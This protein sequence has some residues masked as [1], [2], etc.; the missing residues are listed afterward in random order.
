MTAQQDLEVALPNSL[1]AFNLGKKVKVIYTVTRN[2]VPQNSDELDLTVLLITDGDAN[3]PTPAIDGAIGD[4]LEVMQLAEGAQLRI[5]KWL[6]QAP[7]QCI[8]LRYDGT[9]KNGDAVE[10]TFWAG[11]AHQQVEGL[12]T[13][14][15]V[16]WLR[17]LKDKLP[18]TITFK[19]NFDKIPN[20]ATAVDF[21]VRAY[22]AHTVEYIKPSITKLEDKYEKE[23]PNGGVLRGSTATL[24]GKAMPGKEILLMDNKKPLDELTADQD[25][26]FWNL[27][28]EK[29]LSGQHIFE[30]QA[31]YGDEAVSD[32]FEIE[33]LNDELEDFQTQI[34]RDIPRN[35]PTSISFFDLTWDLVSF[36]R[37]PTGKIRKEN[38]GE[39]YLVFWATGISQR[40]TITIQ[41]TLNNPCSRFDMQYR[42]R[43]RL[44]YENQV[45]FYNSDGTHLHANSMTPVPSGTNDW[46]SLYYS[47]VDIK[48]IEIK[49]TAHGS[50]ELDNF[51]ITY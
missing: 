36:S 7:N 35:V 21:P 43:P 6:L 22:T 39:A 46:S 40:P 14:A 32:P 44:P 18:L 8:W 45:E 16:A 13:P 48:R 34:P 9:N 26:G 4:E 12:I 31:K 20:E 5:E 50:V 3:L 49:T 17:E 25:S 23:I 2:G 51:K 37:P 42:Y 11:G 29:L 10:K 47:G 24:T 38:D 33:V 41:I 1:V 28:I 19:V 30:A 27:K 15:Q